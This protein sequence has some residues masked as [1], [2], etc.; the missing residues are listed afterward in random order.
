MGLSLQSPL[1]EHFFF[2]LQQNVSY[3]IDKLDKHNMLMLL[4]TIIF[5]LV[6]SR[7]TC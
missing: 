6:F 4:Y 1:N 3:K 2:Y 5:T 7:H